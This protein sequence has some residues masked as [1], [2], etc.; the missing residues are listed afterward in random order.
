MEKAP[1][2]SGCN[3]SVTVN[4]G[5][6]FSNVGRIGGGRQLV[7]ITPLSAGTSIR[8]PFFNSVPCGQLSGA[9]VVRP[10]VTLVSTQQRVP[11]IVLQHSERVWQAAIKLEKVFLKATYKSKK[12]NQEIYPSQRG[13]YV[14][15]VI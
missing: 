2:S 9:A 1:D 4:S 13:A 6:T 15:Y 11:A 10:T 3:L 12:G 8:P 5:L 7:T 14:Y